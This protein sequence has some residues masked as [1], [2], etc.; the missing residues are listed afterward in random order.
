MPTL[1]RPHTIIPNT[2]QMHSHHSS[3]PATLGKSPVKPDPSKPRR[4]T[5]SCQAEP[6]Y[7]HDFLAFGRAN[8]ISRQ[9]AITCKSASSVSCSP[10]HPSL[11]LLRDIVVNLSSRW[12]IHAAS[13]TSTPSTPITTPRPSRR[14]RR[15]AAQR[16]RGS[17][18][19]APRRRAASP[20]HR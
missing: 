13:T 8:A 20:T 14:R 17:F 10:R 12:P 3:A 19:T 9:P 5:A 1:Q 15:A 18:G 2:R 16:V 11:P 6:P 7:G 4:R